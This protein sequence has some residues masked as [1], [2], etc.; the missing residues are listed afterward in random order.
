[1]RTTLRLVRDGPA[2]FNA[3]VLW[4]ES[5]ADILNGFGCALLYLAGGMVLT[6]NIISLAHDTGF[7]RVAI[8][9]SILGFAGAFLLDE[10]ATILRDRLTESLKRPSNGK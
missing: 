1:M 7:N 8:S 6:G 10:A 2:T 9:M 3:Y 5:R 4:I